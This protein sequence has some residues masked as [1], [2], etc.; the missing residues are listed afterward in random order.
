MKKAIIVAQSG[1]G[2]S[3]PQIVY[4][5]NSLAVINFEV[6]LLQCIHP[7]ASIFPAGFLD[8]SV[9]V[10]S[11]YPKIPMWSKAGFSEFSHFSAKRQ[12]ELK[13]DYIFSFDYAGVL[14]ASLS[15]EIAPN[16]FTSCIFMLENIDYMIK[17]HGMGALD[18]LTSIWE[19]SIIVYPEVNRLNLDVSSYVNK[20]PVN[21]RLFII[22]PTSPISSDE[23]SNKSTLNDD[24]YRF[25]YAGSIVEESFAIEFGHCLKASGLNYVYDLYGVVGPNYGDHLNLMINES[26]GKVT[27]N[28]IVDQSRLNEIY[29]NY[30]YSFT[31][32]K[33]VSS[34]Y[35]F[36]CPNKFFQTI[37]NRVIPIT[38]DH[39]IIHNV[40]D[41]FD[42]YSLQLSWDQN[43][44]A[45]S[46]KKSI[47]LKDELTKLGDSNYEI[48]CK[49]LSWQVQF[50]SFRKSLKL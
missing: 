38:L 29:G 37:K 11:F 32:W 26:S 36:A 3:D 4:L 23:Q 30:D 5:A 28:G 22:S 17:S 21:E 48:F 45:D 9:K 12:T 19:K 20:L 33:P 24:V 27:H 25:I 2:G 49:E 39:P 16:T 46:L 42:I 7:K 8:S 40:I 31:G 47:K 18:V 50:E 41:F 6:H 14:T 10:E 44:W 34:N 1:V 35:Y 43:L 13:A 15:N